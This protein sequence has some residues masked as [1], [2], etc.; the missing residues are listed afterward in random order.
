MSSKPIKTLVEPATSQAGGESLGCL[1]LTTDDADRAVLNSATVYGNGDLAYRFGTESKTAMNATILLALLGCQAPAAPANSQTPSAIEPTPS[2]AEKDEHG[3]CS[4]NRKPDWKSNY[5]IAHPDDTKCAPWKV[6]RESCRENCC[7]PPIAWLRCWESTCLDPV[8]PMTK[9][10]GCHPWSHLFW[11]PRPEEKKDA[12][13]KNGDEKKGEGA[14]KDSE[15]KAS[16]GDKKNGEQA[17]PEAKQNESKNGEE[18]KN[19][20][21]SKEPEK[22]ETLTPLM[23]VVRRGAPCKYQRMKKKGDNLY[24]WIQ[25]G[26]TMNPASPNDRINFGPNFN[27]RS[28]D[29]RLNQFYLVYENTLEQSDATN[30]GYR[31]DVMG[32]HD[33]GFLVANGLLDLV[34]GHD[35]TSG[36]G[37]EG[38]GSFRHVNRLGVDLPQFYFDLHI[39]NCLTEKGVDVRIGKFYTLMGREVYPATGM[40]FYSRS[41]ENIVATPFTH[42][43]AMATVHLTDT[44]DL[45][46]GIVEGW[47]VFED[48]NDKP[49]AHGAVIWNSCDKRR[50][51]TTC[52]ITGP[53]QFQNND[54]IRTLATSYYTIK[55]GCHNEWMYSFGGN[56]AYEANAVANV[57]GGLDSAEWYGVQN[58]LFYNVDK[59]TILGLRA[60]W[61]RDDDGTRTA[62]HGRPGY[63]A[64][65]YEL[66]NGLTYKPYQNLRIR[67]EV[68]F[69]YCP[70]ARPYNDQN[71]KFQFTAAFDVLYEF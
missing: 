10:C 54:N 46:G 70:D 30:V 15:K 58:F 71:D 38:P 44:V 26:F 33:A 61:F 9:L 25:Q 14:S 65:F 5:L 60:E 57:A 23:D 66:T 35:P 48:N 51:W 21:E 42:T 41:Y 56:L 53:E 7:L 24:G 45:Y 3:W 20:E 52:W 4:A 27:Q 18:K 19:G 49:S 11:C 64:N 12:E 68:R 6:R 34:T 8:E 32:G 43:G 1:G 59:T 62:I 29:Y 55:W 37:V 17:A 63:A 47:D 50:N 2:A 22:E 69:D 31:V 13:K 40:E 16:A 28:N 39:P 67:P 36:F